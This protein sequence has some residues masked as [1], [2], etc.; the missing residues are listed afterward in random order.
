M[1]DL[2]SFSLSR[3]VSLSQALS[4]YDQSNSSDLP[5]TKPEPYEKP[6]FKNNAIHDD[7]DKREDRSFPRVSLLTQPN[8]PLVRLYFLVTVA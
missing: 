2:L 1:H 7:N 4:R 3:L 5:W 6:I 8:L